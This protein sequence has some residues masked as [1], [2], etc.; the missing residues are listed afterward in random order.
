MNLYEFFYQVFLV[1]N[2]WVTIKDKSFTAATNNIT[3]VVAGGGTIE[4]LNSLLLN[5]SGAAITLK[6]DGM[7]NYFII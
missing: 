7:G 3:L 6:S 1:K 5:N 2:P 4:G